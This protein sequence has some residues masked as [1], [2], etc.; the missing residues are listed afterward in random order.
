MKIG[1]LLIKTVLTP[2][3]KSLIIPIKLTAAESAGDSGIHK[4]II[5]SRNTTLMISN[6]EMNCIKRMVKSL[7][8]SGILL[9]SVS[10]TIENERKENNE[11]VSL[12]FCWMILVLLY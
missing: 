10:E 2:L 11:V 8:N 4:K 3:A 12:A 7:E 5:Q 6:K 9:K 1:L